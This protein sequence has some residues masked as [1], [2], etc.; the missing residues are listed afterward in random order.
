MRKMTLGYYPGCSGLGTSLE[1]DM[2]TRAVCRALG[3]SLVDIPD[4]TC[5]GSTPVHTVDGVLAA[6]VAARNFAQAERVGI[7]KVVTPCPSCLKNLR[8]ALEGMKDDFF[9][10]RVDA[11]TERPLLKP[12]TVRSVLQVIVE[13][14]GIDTIRAGVTRPLAG[15]KVVPYYGCL[16][17]RPADVMRFDNPENPMAMD[18]LLAALG[19]EVL[20]FSMKVECC[21]ASMSIPARDIVPRLG[22]KILAAASEVGADCV[23]VACPLCQ[24]NLDLRQGQINRANKTKYHLPVPY[25]TQLLGHALGLPE[26]E[27]GLSKLILDIQPLL[28]RRPVAKAAEGTASPA[29]QTGG[30]A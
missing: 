4:W 29:P 15:L 7:D 12:H 22:N 19:A 5:C 17:S 20:P 25:F 1:Y 27:L 8:N 11:L 30:Q 13:D 26:G 24:M 6:A 23:V 10:A 21:G 18:N 2:S 16:M 9:R 3:I 14:I 28:Y